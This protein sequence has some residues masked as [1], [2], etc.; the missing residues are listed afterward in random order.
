MVAVQ[1]QNS[2]EEETVAFPAELGARPLVMALGVFDGVHRGHQAI[3]RELLAQGERLGGEPA[4]VFFDPHPR[5]VLGRGSAPL[6]LSGTA[7]RMARMRDLG[8]QHIVCFPFTRELAALSPAEFYRRYLQGLDIRGYCVGEDWRFGAGNAGDGASLRALSGVEVQVV[9]PVLY[10]GKT[11]SST[12]IRAALE[13]G[14]VREAAAMLGRPYRLCG[15][16]CHGQGLGSAALSYPT[17]NVVGHGVQLPAFGVY[18]ARGEV[19]GVRHDGI[20]YVGDAPTMR[21]HDVI[22]EMHM[23]DFAGDLYGRE[24]S[25]EF[26]ERLRESRVFASP[27]ALKEQIAKDVQ[28]ARRILSEG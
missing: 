1:G 24:L 4:A 12:R 21:G 10:E 14:E 15:A 3:F 20:V 11:V 26:V 5:V 23:F 13:C 27:E 6:Q 28:E 9:P 25:V 8:I 18:A 2:S 22:V 7:D 17:A 16:V 19:D